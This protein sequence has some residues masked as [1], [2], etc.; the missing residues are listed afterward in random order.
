[1]NSA[2]HAVFDTPEAVQ[3]DRARQEAVRQLLVTLRATF[4]LRSALD[5]GCGIGHFSCFLK[6]LGFS[7]V[8]ADGREENISEAKLR[9]PQI[10]FHVA[11]V[12]ADSLP[13]LGRFDLVF[14]MGLLYHLENPF[15]AIRGLRSVTRTCLVLESMCLSEPT[16][17]MLLREEP[18]LANQSLTDVAFYPTEGCLVKMLY[19]A[20]FSHVYR[21]SQLP[22]H[23]DFRDTADHVRRRTVLLAGLAPIDSQELI[24]LIEPPESRD[25]WSKPRPRQRTLP[26]RIKNFLRKPF[27][28]QSRSIYF[29]WKRILPS[30]PF[31][32][33]LPFGAWF[34]GRNDVLGAFL[35]SDD[36]EAD[37]RAFVRRFLQPGMTVLDIG[38]HHGLYT[39]L[40]S[41]MTGRSG[42][43]FAFEPSP[44]E[45]KAL[46]LNVLLNRRKNVSIQPFAL[47]DKLC[48]SDMY[49][50]EGQ[51]TG[52][53]SLRPPAANV[54]TAMVPVEVLTLDD[55][56]EKRSI[57]RPDFIKLDVEGAELSVIKGAGKVLSQQPRPVIMAEVESFRTE[58]WGYSAMDII[59]SLQ[60]LD[61]KWFKPVHGG[62]LR[63]FNENSDQFLGNFVAIPAER[64]EEVLARVAQTC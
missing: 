7:V 44:R 14:C 21:L 35:T 40:A 20:G 1:M 64:R 37:E 51:E 38:A 25:P 26:R 53:N 28:E 31:P 49:I 17:W 56:F 54:A 57:P 15:R 8:A 2:A 36:F 6:E 63:P 19:R 48:H 55:L 33:R 32:V 5:I 23:D 45:R 39:L 16:P 34:I 27:H 46:R 47:G 30:I 60:D 13:L 61:F 59:K 12:E 62:Q 58:P 3:I 29:H 22:D 18:Q 50:V 11:N 42:T 4:G 52:L 9:Y 43:V 41:S 10:D 24:P